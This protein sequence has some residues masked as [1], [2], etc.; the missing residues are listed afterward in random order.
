MTDAQLLAPPRPAPGPPRPYRFPHFERHE[1]T[2]GLGVM[3][4]PMRSYPITT[5][6][7]MVD[8]GATSDARGA[9]G[10]TS[11]MATALAEGTGTM[12]ALQLA[13]RL[14][15]VGSTLDAGADWDSTVVQLSALP[16]RLD[17]AM[18]VLAEV[19]RAPAFPAGD[20]ERLVAERL[21]QI[22]QARTE[23][24]AL[25][26]RSFEYVAYAPSSRFVHSAGGN[27]PS[28]TRLDRAA[29]VA[30][31]A[32]HVTPAA[33]TVIVVGDIGIDEAVAL[34]ERHL[35]GWSG[36]AIPPVRIDTSRRHASRTVRIVPMAEA[37]QAELRIGHVAVPR[38]HP[39]Y[40]PLTLMNAVLG[41]LFSSR[42]NLNL[43]E[44]HGWTYG[45]HSS[46]DWRR[47]AS[48]FH[49]STAVATEVTA[50]AVRETLGEIDRIRAEPVREEELS[51][52]TSYLDGVFPIRYET[53][54]AVASALANLHVF[55]LPSDYFDTYRSRVRAVTTAE[56]LRVARA[57]LVP[58]ALQVVVAGDAA[59]LTAP[60]SALDIGPVDVLP[61]AALDAE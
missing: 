5:V 11:L 25:A 58:E 4:A 12:D 53:T 21:A 32:R 31:H 45:A 59:A 43:R 30:H 17:D 33:T 38:A 35:G 44:A 3:V 42:I 37:A 28:V 29:L 40:F 7:A 1:L 54:S 26:D 39:D 9:E 13:E 50:D 34:V 16:N 61:V 52:A 60:L 46:F 19:L 10:L 27:R 41:G 6:L 36:A 51:L 22:A 24:R 49:V 2:N 18:A 23:P 57:H 56:V 15:R 8:L 47:D 14:E 55:G 20:V 48:P